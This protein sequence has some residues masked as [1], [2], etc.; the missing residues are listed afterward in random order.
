VKRVKQN[1]IIDIILLDDFPLLVL[2]FSWVSPLPILNAIGIFCLMLSFWCIYEFGYYENDLVA[3]KYE[4]KPVLSHTYYKRL[5]TIQWWQPWIWSLIIGLLGVC[6]VV[7]SEIAILDISFNFHEVTTNSIA[8]RW[9]PI[10]NSDRALN[11]LFLKAFYKWTCFLL[12]SRLG[13]FVYNYVNKQTRIWLYPVLQSTR[14]CGFLIVAV[15]NMVG[16]CIIM[17]Y[18]LARST[19]YLVYRYSGGNPNDWPKLQDWFLRLIFFLLFIISISIV[20][21]DLTLLFNWQTAV[22]VFWLFKKCRRQAVEIIKNIK[23][24]WDEEVEEKP[25]ELTTSNHL[26]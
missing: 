9:N 18:V 20:E 21:S 13:F 25:L 12:I 4:L 1:Y 16:V 2:A 19:T 26:K 5:I 23:F 7:A 24:I 10:D 6:L 11:S 14:Y 8:L 22:L 3:E 15:T 17:S